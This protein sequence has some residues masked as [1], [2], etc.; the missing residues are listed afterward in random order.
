M[1]NLRSH[2]PSPFY[3]SELKCV[4]NKLVDLEQSERSN[5]LVS[6]FQHRYRGTLKISVSGAIQ[7]C[8]KERVLE[9][10][11]CP[12]GHCTAFDIREMSR[13]LVMYV[14]VELVVPDF[15]DVA[16]HLKILLR[17]H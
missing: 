16:L 8:S 5:H 10:L 9:Y 6:Y 12:P 2:T 7:I 1:K 13:V 15:V 3:G 11:A 17:S 4:P 14:T